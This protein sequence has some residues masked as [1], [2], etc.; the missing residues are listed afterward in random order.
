MLLLSLL[1]P[2]AFAQTL[3]YQG[4]IQG[5]MAID[6]SGVSTAYAGTT[7]LYTGDTLDITIPST[8]T[9][10]EVWAVVTAKASGFNGDPATTTV[11]NGVYLSS[12][13]YVSASGYHRVYKLDPATFGITKAGSY[14]YQ[15]QDKADSGYQ[16]GA[17]T[18]GTTLAVIYEDTTLSGYRH[19][20]FG[21][22][23][24]ANG[25]W[26]ITGLPTTKGGDKVLYSQTV[27]WECSDEQDGTM[28]I[29][30]TVTT[31]Y[32]GGRDDGKNFTAACGSQ[33][34][35]SLFTAGSFG[36]NNSDEL[37]GVDGDEPDSESSS[38][39]SN[40]SL[41]S[42]ELWRVTY[43]K[44]GSLA[45]K[46]AKSDSDGYT[47]AF[48]LVIDLETDGD[49]VNNDDDNCPDVSN[50]DQ[51]DADGDG[52][53]DA[54]DTCTDVDGD[55]Y[56]DGAYSAS[57]CTDD[58]DD[59]DAS[60]Y[61]GASDA[62]YDGVDANCDGANDYDRDGDGTTSSSYGG[63]DCND[64][65][66]SVN[67]SA[68]ETYYDGVDANCDGKSDYDKDGD[69]TDSSSY[70]GTDC[71]DNNSSVNTGATETYYDGVDAN[72]DGKSDYDK[73]G[74]GTDSSSYG[75]TDCN[76][77]NASVNTSATETYYDGVDA[78][79]DGKSDYDKDGDGTDSSSY[80]GTDCNDNNASVNTSATE[81]YYDG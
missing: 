3:H 75:G 5:G 38:G 58:C 22:H 81:T 49:G 9:V 54:C 24:T 65:N 11:I 63:T 79:C 27:G 59:D 35:N 13:T 70:G 45:V 50:A 4:D 56:G 28:T 73:D 26:T 61:P 76:D 1:A 34:W 48:G 80:G 41:R 71:N 37:I 31:A 72:C 19:I 30:S 40:N 32:A 55:T 12:G 17:G 15:E 33:D 18:V 62:W 16:G 46:Y 57:T 44:T 43:A 36:I 78:N 60:I 66:S 10:K 39:T 53:G 67:T 23:Y 29:G 7:T 69:G 2:S 74:D 21:T 47:S 6:G 64:N 68:T 25:S 14:S 51:A 42:D 8:A 20:V 77:N 52:D